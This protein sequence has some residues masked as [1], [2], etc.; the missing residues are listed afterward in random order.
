MFIVYKIT[1]RI[2]Q[3]IYFGYTGRSLDA[4][5]RGHQSA[6][7]QGSK[8]RF[9]SAIRKYGIDN[10]ELSVV[11]TF[12]SKLEAQQYETDL[13][14]EYKTTDSKF[15][16]NGAAGGTGGWVIPPEK[17]DSWLEKIT[18]KS[19]GFNNPRCYQITDDEILDECV[20]IC[21]KFGRIISYRKIVEEAL[22]NGVNIPKTFTKF[23]FNGSKEYFIS[24]LE[25]KTGFKHEPNKKS[26][27]TREKLKQAN[28]GNNW[29]F[30]DELKKCIQSKEHNLDPSYQWIRGRKK[31]GN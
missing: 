1:N 8:F 31:Y 21:M 15:G 12:E 18:I 11:S 14:I 19:T 13:I 24:L 25:E 4:R 5:W 28:I 29:W 7:R 30:C 22:K 27:E 20:K 23:R 2:N 16:Y 17:Y 26:E 6:S 3:K 10:W 9:H